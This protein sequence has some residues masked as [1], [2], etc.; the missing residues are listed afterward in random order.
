MAVQD[1][2][3][4]EEKITDKAKKADKLKISF[5]VSNRIAATGETFVYVSVKDPSGHLITD[6]TMGSGSFTSRDSVGGDIQYSSKMPVEFETG[7]IKTVNFSMKGSNG[8]QK[9]TYQICIYH[10]GY[11]IGEASKELKKGGLFS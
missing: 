8:F 5:D 10:N 4:G 7:K 2:K 6:S 1:K 11:K 9:G 3:N